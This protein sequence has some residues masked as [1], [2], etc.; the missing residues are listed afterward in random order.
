MFREAQQRGVGEAWRDAQVRLDDEA[1]KQL[2]MALLRYP[3]VVRA[4]GEHLEP[5]RLCQHML[6]IANRF[7]GFYQSCKVLGAED[8][9]TRNSRLWLCDLTARVLEDGLGVLGLPTLERM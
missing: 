4:V 5:H 1:E 7:S 6:E 2:A 3:S 8:D 9:A